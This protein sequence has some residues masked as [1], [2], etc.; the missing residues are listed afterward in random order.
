LFRLEVVTPGMTGYFYSVPGS[1]LSAQ[2]AI[3]YD[4]LELIPEDEFTDKARAASLPLV[5]I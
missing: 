5:R 1:G 4:Y 3:W 2:D